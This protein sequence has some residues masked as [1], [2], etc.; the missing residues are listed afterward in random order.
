MLALG[1]DLVA[2]LFPFLSF[3]A[4]QLAGTCRTL[5]D[6][7]Y[8]EQGSFV[9]A[10]SIYPTRSL[11]LNTEGED[12]N[13][14][15]TTSITTTT[16]TST[17]TTTTTSTSTWRGLL[18]SD[19]A[20]NGMW[21]LFPNVI[22]NWK[23]NSPQHFYQNRISKM[24]VDWRGG[25]RLV[26]FVD[27]RGER[28]LRGGRR[29]CLLAASGGTLVSKVL[30]AQHTVHYLSEGHVVMELGFPLSFFRPGLAYHYCFDG[31]ADLSGS[32]Y[33]CVEAFRLPAHTGM[34]AFFH[35]FAQGLP[36]SFE[37]RPFSYNP[38]LECPKPH[39]WGLPGPICARFQQGGWGG[40]I[41]PQFDWDERRGA[42]GTPSRPH[43]RRPSV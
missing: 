6:I 38:R 31:C 36:R 15:T 14:P 18:E 35:P 33:E 7:V 5:R 22:C 42:E 39:T 3:D 11:L 17:T 28:D 27:A 40:H 10:K 12:A 1:K 8:S 23:Y 2:F 20:A 16:T 32:D 43:R 21:C 24:G 9:L 26:L 29:T 41:N 4:L 13:T 25:G 30:P 34:R 19:N 37:P